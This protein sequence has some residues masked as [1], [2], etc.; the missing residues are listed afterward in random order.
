MMLHF[1]REAF[2]V[3]LAQARQHA[4]QASGLGHREA[5]G[6][7]G[8]TL[9]RTMIVC[10]SLSLS[11]CAANPLQPSVPLS[12]TAT[13]LKDLAPEPLPGPTAGPIPL[14]API[15]SPPV[16]EPP[17]G[18]IW[19]EP[20]TPEPEPTPSGTK[21]PDLPPVPPLPVRIHG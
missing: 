2:G 21:K 1:V 13:S 12:V 16:T 7:K 18:P 11:A 8:R 3:Q 9:M 4:F 19:W 10:V 15:V 17:E 14:P 20:T 5:A 6:M